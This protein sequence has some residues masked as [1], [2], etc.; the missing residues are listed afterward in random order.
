[1]T[2]KNAQ[3]KIN[4]ILDSVIPNKIYKKLDSTLRGNIGAELV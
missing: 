4:Q 3:N 2:I 1:M